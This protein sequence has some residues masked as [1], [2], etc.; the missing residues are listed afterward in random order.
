MGSYMA[1]DETLI[2]R[3]VAERLRQHAERVR[4]RQLEQQAS[5]A[6]RASSAEERRRAS[7]PVRGQDVG[8]ES[9][10]QGPLQLEGLRFAIV[11]I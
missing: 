3:C 9:D 6:R 7:T 11:K 1:V 2:D 8:M 10:E 4:Q 5:A